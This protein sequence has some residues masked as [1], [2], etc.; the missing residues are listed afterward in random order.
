MSDDIRVYITLGVLNRPEI[1]K[2]ELDRLLQK[3]EELMTEAT[4]ITQVIRPVVGG[5]GEAHGKIEP[6]VMQMV[7]VNEQI[8]NKARAWMDAREERNHLIEHVKDPLLRS[9]LIAHYVEQK[10]CRT[11]A[12]ENGIREESVRRAIKKAL[13]EVSARYVP[14]SANLAP[15]SDENTSG[16]KIPTEG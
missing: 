9:L 16:D 13:G 15:T 11:I 5:S 6:L 10:S 14:T 12:K 7:L 3:H 1:L 8:G 4:H 2:K